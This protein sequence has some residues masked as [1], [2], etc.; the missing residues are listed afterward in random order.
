MGPK[1]S[2]KARVYVHYPKSSVLAYDASTV[3][4]YVLG[5]VGI[6]LGFG[7]SW[8]ANLFGGLYMAF[9]FGQMYVLMPL[10]VCP[11]CVY[12]RMEGS[13]CVSGMN[14]VSRKVARQGRLEDFPR[15]GQGLFCHNNA[16]IA[17]LAI[18]IIAMIPALALNFSFILL[19]IFLVV[20]GLLLF[21]FFV[22]FPK[23][24]CIH[25]A[26]K[27]GCPNARS[28]GLGGAETTGGV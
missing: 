13:L 4:H 24:A 22:L 23:I 14:V 18:P 25:C 21:R 26:A 28:M 5:G 3:A 20:V 15:R 12:Y 9:S 19:A 2:A 11:K 7:F 1:Q 8:V 10:T 6:M 27:H 16:Y 17:S